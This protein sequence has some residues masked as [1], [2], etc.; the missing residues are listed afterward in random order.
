MRMAKILGCMTLAGLLGASKPADSI[1][2]PSQAAADTALAQFDHD[3]PDCQLWSNWQKMC[4]RTGEGG[5]TLCNRDRRIEARPSTPFCAARFVKMPGEPYF[6]PPEAPETLTESAASGGSRQ[7]FCKSLWDGDLRR[8]PFEPAIAAQHKTVLLCVAYKNPRPFDG[9][10]VHSQANPRCRKWTKEG[11][12]L[13]RCSNPVV[14]ARCPMLTN[15]VPE[16]HS[17]SDGIYTGRALTSEVRPI[18]GLYC[19]SKVN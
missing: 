7:R 11:G 18:W 12:G 15:G 6:R 8:V 16:L 14:D 5:K 10:D 13:Y 1:Y 19:V 2:Y 4:S 9:L 3:N 17:S